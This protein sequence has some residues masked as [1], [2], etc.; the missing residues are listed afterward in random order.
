MLKVDKTKELIVAFILVLLYSFLSLAYFV[1]I[2][3]KLYAKNFFNCG[4]AFCAPMPYVILVVLYIFLYSI[5]LKDKPGA[6]IPPVIAM[7]VILPLFYLLVDLKI[8]IGVT[9]P[10]GGNRGIYGIYARIYFILLLSLFSL[11][12]GSLFRKTLKNRMWPKAGPSSGIPNAIF[13]L[14]IFIYF[15][16]I[17]VMLFSNGL[18]PYAGYVIFLFLL[19]LSLERASLLLRTVKM[20]LVRFATNERLFLITIFIIAFLV[21]FLWGLRLLGITGGNF[22]IASDDGISYDAYAAILAQGGLIPKEMIFENSGFGYWHFL[23]AVYK[24]FGLHNFRAMIIIQ[25]CISAF[26]PVLIYF[27]GKKLFKTAFVPVLA[28]LLTCFDMMLIFLSAVIGIEAIYIPLVF[29]A[30]CLAIYFLNRKN[31]NCKKAFLLGATFGLAY[32][33]RSPELLLFP[34]ILACIIYV[35]MRKRLGKVR[36]TGIIA[37]L[38]IGFILLSSVQYVMNYVVYGERRII[39]ASATVGGFKADTIYVNENKILVQMGFS[40]F[41]DFKG[42]VSTFRK[43]PLAVSRLIIKGFFKRLVI[44]YT[45]PN[46]GVFDAVYLVNPKSGYFFRFPVYVQ[47]CGYL[48]VIVG[49]AYA[50]I[51]R[52]NLAGLVILFAFFAYISARIGFFFILN[53]RYRGIL[54]PIFFIFLAYGLEVFYKKVKYVY[55]NRN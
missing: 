3:P 45:F 4:I 36:I 44:L 6:V 54:L 11:L 21:R 2:D 34:F 18:A 25:S 35:F 38:F 53:A 39:P 27:I 15:V 20:L 50:F 24:I 28:S 41:E 14:P 7:A 26:V 9:D 32:S 30:L 52:E 22:I 23:A 1:I 5:L 48:L 29:L 19:A 31:P 10:F 42:S 33:I 13:H 43:R 16:F 40:P 47:C 17:E 8:G 12:G 49:M 51:K 55:V 46:F 37:F